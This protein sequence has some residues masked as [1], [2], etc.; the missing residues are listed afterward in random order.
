[1][2]GVE[3]EVVVVI[4]SRARRTMTEVVED[5]EVSSHE[6][7]GY[8]FLLVEIDGEFFLCSAGRDS[9]LLYFCCTEI[10]F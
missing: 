4:R 3:E 9:C 2:V 10:Y 8:Y 7:F 5:A 1:M 6:C